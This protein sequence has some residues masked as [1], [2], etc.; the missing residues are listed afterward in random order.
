[1]GM[2]TSLALE[3]ILVVAQRQGRFAVAS[4]RNERKAFDRRV[5][6][7]TIVSPFQGMYAHREYRQSL[8]KRDV[9]LHALRTVAHLHPSWTFCSFTAA[10][11]WGLDVSN[12]LLLPLNVASAPGGHRYSTPGLIRCRIVAEDACATTR[13]IRVTPLE[14]TLLDCACHGGFRYGLA[15]C[16]SALHWGLISPEQ[17]RSYVERCGKGRHGIVAARKVMR[18]MDGRSE[19]GGE[20]LVRAV[21]IELGFE[22]PELQV[23]VDDPM[24]P[25]A[26]RKV[27]YYWR[28][29]NGKV[30]IL[31]L[32]GLDKYYIGRSR[33]VAGSAR[34]I[35]RRFSEERLRESHINLTGATVLRASFEQAMDEDYLFRLLLQAGVPL[36]S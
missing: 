21:M 14:R 9:A 23:E 19:N 29:L 8:S 31:E 11:A 1:M 36:R 7:G 4:T 15:I 32:D 34:D 33:A 17:L 18:Y 35:A 27:D 25:G 28:L 6:R 20:S 10:L 30:I 26:P 13:G 2:D 24:R 5:A 12:V 22:V 3:R 16:D